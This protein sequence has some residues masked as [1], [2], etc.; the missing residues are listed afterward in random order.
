ME[1][2]EKEWTMDGQREKL[3]E[4]LSELL[5]EAAEVS[6]ALDYVDE[7][8]P[9]VPHYIEI[10]ERAHELGQRLSCQIQERRMAEIVALENSKGAC[11]E[12]GRR[13]ELTPQK[14]PV[15]SADGK[16]ALQE[17]KGY[18]PFCRKS[19]FPSEDETGL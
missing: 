8:S 1:F 11:P 3:E 4:K 2:L 19:F 10:E 14:R 18:C 9:R 13:S 16:V 6:V 5:R 12:C 17:L 15:R 7:T